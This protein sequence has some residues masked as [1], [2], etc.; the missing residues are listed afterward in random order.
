MRKARE[1]THHLLR[2][3]ANREHLARSIAQLRSKLTMTKL[4]ETAESDEIEAAGPALAVA[5]Q[6]RKWSEL[7]RFKRP[8]FDVDAYSKALEKDSDESD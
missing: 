7:E 4:A 1:T 8:D 6:R 3:P 2:S 5:L